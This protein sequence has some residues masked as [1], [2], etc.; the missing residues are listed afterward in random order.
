MDLAL[1]SIAIAAQAVVAIVVLGA[2]SGGY[3]A[4]DYLAYRWAVEHVTAGL[5]VYNTTAPAT[6]LLGLFLYP[7]TFL[8]LA[9]PLAALPPLDAAVAWTATLLAASISAIL[10]LPVRWRVRWLVL[11]LSAA[12]YPS[13]QALAQGQVGPILLLLAALGWR[14]LDRPVRL[15]ATI[16]LGAAIKLQPALLVGW[17]VITDRRRAAAFAVVLFC[18]LAAAATVLAGPD[19]WG[20]QLASLARTN[21]PILTPNSVGPAHLALVSGASLAAAYAA[22]LI[23][24][25]ATIIVTAYLAWRGPADVS[26]LAV[27]VACQLI[28]PVIWLHY[29]VV[30]LLPMAW[31]LDRGRWIAL[32]VPI[33]LSTAL[34]D[35]VPPL[36]AFAA[37]WAIL[38]GLAWEGLRDAAPAAA[39]EVA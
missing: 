12:F 39:L 35:V 22:M 10:V 31:L 18:L 29:A 19:S 13:L 33:A 6:G 28:S 9:L 7:P 14:W 1:A 21:D 38:A 5:P 26:Y 23:N 24:L 16:A 2:V 17:A 25:A 36:I 15:G 27:V 3:Q 8:V 4:H 20:L 30:L 37:Y 34:A 11:A 32:A